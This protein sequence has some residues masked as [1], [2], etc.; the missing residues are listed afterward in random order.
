MPAE[1]VMNTQKRN[2]L[3]LAKVQIFVSWFFLFLGGIF[4]I[5]SWV[6]YGFRELPVYVDG[7]E[8]GKFSYFI[9]ACAGGSLMILLSTLSIYAGKRLIRS[10][11]SER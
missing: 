11:M 9:L 4:P 8:S 7:V 2:I 5:Y 3:I 10:L 1:V 6:E